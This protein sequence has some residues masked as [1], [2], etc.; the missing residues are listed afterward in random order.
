MWAEWD[1][2]VKELLELGHPLRNRFDEMALNYPIR[3][4]ESLITMAMTI[5]CFW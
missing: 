2:I 3:T 4:R 1:V 5:F